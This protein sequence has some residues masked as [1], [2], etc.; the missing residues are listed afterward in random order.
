MSPCFYYRKKFSYGNSIFI[1]VIKCKIMQFLYSGSIILQAFYTNTS[2][3]CQQPAN[4]IT[5]Y[6]I[7]FLCYWNFKILICVAYMTT[8]C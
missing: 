5:L 3:T 1:L 4:I 6:C 8:L 7:F 2:I